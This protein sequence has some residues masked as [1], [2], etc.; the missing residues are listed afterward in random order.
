[1]D[2]AEDMNLIII[3]NYENTKGILLDKVINI[4]VI[5][6]ARKLESKQFSCYFAPYYRVVQFVGGLNLVMGDHISQCEL[7][8]IGGP[9]TRGQVC[10]Y[11]TSPKFNLATSYDIEKLKQIQ[12]NPDV[13]YVNVLKS[14]QER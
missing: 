12:R 4:I 6:F 5:P 7:S 10:R 1:M 11:L 14:T 13:A 8:G 9:L 2:S 3:A